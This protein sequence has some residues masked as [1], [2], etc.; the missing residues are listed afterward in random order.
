MTELH[1]RGAVGRLRPRPPLDAV[2]R[3]DR[4][5][6]YGLGGQLLALYTRCDGLGSRDARLNPDDLAASIAGVASSREHS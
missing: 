1:A 2:V 6:P 3:A 4:S 5:L